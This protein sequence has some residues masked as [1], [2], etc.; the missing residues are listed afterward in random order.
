MRVFF[1]VLSVFLLALP[2]QGQRRAKE[3]VNNLQNFDKKRLQFGYYIGLNYYNY[4]IDYKKNL[5]PVMVKPASGLNIGLVAD[6]RIMEHLN[7]RFEPGLASMQRELNFLNRS[8]FTKDSDTLRNV[9]STYI[10]LPLLL[11][12]STQR[13][14]NIRPFILGGIA[15]SINLSSEENNP[16]DNINQVF[17]TKK[18]T[19]Y[20]ELGLGIDFYMNYFKFSPSIRGVFAISD[21]L[22]PDNDPDSPWTGNISGLRSRGIFLNFTFH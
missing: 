8:G 9:K 7:V 10:H 16:D 15:T 21:E 14:N 22:V 19:L 5:P 13:L 1:L 11:K 4:K 17:R 6:Y 3:K 20:Y 18:Q 12:V 2:V